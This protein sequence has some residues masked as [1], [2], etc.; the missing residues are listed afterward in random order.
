MYGAEDVDLSSLTPP[1]DPSTAAA[2]SH[3][4]WKDTLS[5][6]PRPPMAAE[7]SARLHASA[8]AGAQVFRMAFTC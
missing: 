1:V 3:T 7:K 4:R 5:P 6:A 8:T 2:I